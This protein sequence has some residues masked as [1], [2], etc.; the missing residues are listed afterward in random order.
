MSLYSNLFAP[1]KVGEMTVKNR[2]F[3]PPVSTHLADERGLVTDELL[4]YYEK[5]AKGGVGLITVPSVLIE[6]LSR[7]GTYRNLCLYEANHVGNMKKLTDCVHRHGTKICAQLLHPSIACPPSYNEGR[8][9][10]AA[11]AVEG[12]SYT[13]IPREITID[14]I[15]D[16]VNKFGNAAYLAKLAGFDGVELHCCHK[17]GLLGNFISPLHNKRTDMYGGNVEGRI[18]FALEVIS[19][20]R[21]KTGKDYPIIVRMSATDEQPGGQ[22]IMEGMYIAK[23]FEEAGASMIHL[24]DGSFDIPYKTTG[25]VGT[26][27]AFNY[28][29][30][31]KI[32]N[33]LSIPLGLVGRINEAWVGELLL[34]QNVCDAVYMGRALVCDPDLPKK[35]A[36]ERE[37]DVMPCIGCLKCLYAANNDL[38]FACTMNP[39]A[40]HELEL[41]RN[42]ETLRNR[43]VLVVGGGPAGLT[44]AFYAA[45]KGHDVTLAERTSHLGGQ[46]NLA[47][48][49]P[50]K[51]EIA[52]GTAYLI[53]RVE[54]AGIKIE[55]NCEIT[56]EKVAEGNFD[57]V[58]IANGNEAV[59]PNFLAGASCLVTARDILSGKV[60]AGKKVVIVGG[61]SVGCETADFILRPLNDLSP[62]S[63]DVTVIETASYVCQDEKTSAR[64]LLIERLLNKGCHIL[65][66]A[67]V[68]SVNG[69]TIIYEKD[70]GENVISGVDMVIAAVGSQ[71]DST[72]KNSLADSG[73]SVYAL[74]ATVNI[75]VA[76]QK[77]FE[78]VQSEL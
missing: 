49:P 19:E 29:Y 63:R 14:E 65:T 53:S 10:V 41:K 37:S 71:A 59:L 31:E 17:H 12:K 51:Q 13:D 47:A 1:I 36:A 60:R 16:Y 35:I 5:R 66:E 9:P 69:D 32:K 7:Y 70:G 50:C 64:S 39:E 44:A 18:R 3:M 2:I 74:E 62:F 40:G 28:D 76:T 57:Y 8:Q 22:T 77:A 75:Q 61:G 52:K 58:I 78:L 25:P 72:L 43:R 54:R 30:A 26:P 11:S 24:S 45:E 4:A 56:P 21:K 42:K 34:E 73:I 38:P 15:K 6:K 46:M 23:R 33:V 55:L 67:N 48:V 68:K 20:I 27:Q